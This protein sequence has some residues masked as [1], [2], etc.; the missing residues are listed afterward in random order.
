MFG[1][2]KIQ[3]AVNMMF[4][5]GAATAVVFGTAIG[6]FYMDGYTESALVL[7]LTTIGLVIATLGTAIY[8]VAEE[9]RRNKKLQKAINDMDIDMDEIQFP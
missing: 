3:N 4:L 6:A 9:S 1:K 2:N 8:V 7:S 5:F